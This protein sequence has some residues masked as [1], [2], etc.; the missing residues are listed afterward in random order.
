MKD[1]GI[2]MLNSLLNA[3]IVTRASKMDRKPLKIMSMDYTHML[4]E[5]N[6]GTLL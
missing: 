6:F 2:I 1:Y 5:N 3:K 4:M